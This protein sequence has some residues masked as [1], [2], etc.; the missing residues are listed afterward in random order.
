MRGDDRNIS[1]LVPAFIEGEMWIAMIILLAAA[2]LTSQPPAVDV[3]A[4]RA[5]ALEV[6]QVFLPKFPQFVPPPHQEMLM[7]AS[8]SFDPLALP[9]VLDRIQSDFNHN[10]SGLIVVVAGICAMLDRVG[11]V[12]FARH[13]PLFFLLLAVFLILLGEPK[14]WPLGNEGFWQT[15]V[16]P[17]V[18]QHRVAT[19]LVAGLAL[20]EWRVLSGELT[21]TRRHFAFPIMCLTGGALLLTHSHTVFA[22]KSAFLIEVSHNAMGLLAVGIGVGRWLDLRLPEPKNPIPGFLWTACLILLG[23]VLLFYREV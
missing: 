19:L 2:A 14:G 13:W 10:V 11:R 8:S 3:L 21:P 9:S 23:F 7:R 18:L 17:E 12:R 1:E 4:E 15:L 16:I 22:I 5:S 20:F 6:L